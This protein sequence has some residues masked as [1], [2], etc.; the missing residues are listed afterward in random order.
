MKDIPLS[1][2]VLMLYITVNNFSVMSG[3]GLNHYL[4]EDSVL[5][6]ET[7]QC[8]KV[9]FEPEAIQPKD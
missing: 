9:S 8:L 4:A 6:K 7:T 2:F 5:P 3:R 1:Q